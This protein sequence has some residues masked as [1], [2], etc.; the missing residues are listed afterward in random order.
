MKATDGCKGGRGPY[1]GEGAAEET[2]GHKRR[3]RAIDGQKAVEGGRV[4]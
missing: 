2:Y 3:L 4:G 1:S